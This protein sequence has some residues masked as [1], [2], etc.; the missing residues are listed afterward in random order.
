MS[1]QE[2][3]KGEIIIEAISGIFLNEEGKILLVRRTPK[4]TYNP[5]TYDLIGGDI[6][7]KETPIQTLLRD[8]KDKLG[9]K[10]N[11]Q[12]T[13]EA[14]IKVINSPNAPIRRHFFIIRLKNN[15]P[16]RLD[17][18]KYDEWGWFGLAQLTQ[19]NLTPGVKE[20]LETTE[21]LASII[22]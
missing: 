20:I 1:R 2:E 17:T 8:A 7:P 21:Q 14:G 13:E 3:E 22:K 5:N 12:D 4:R 6:L 9:I 10:L 16:I 18:K 19:L 15:I 11:T